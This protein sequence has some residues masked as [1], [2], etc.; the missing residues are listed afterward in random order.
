[1]AQVTS[2]IPSLDHFDC[3]GDPVSV[4]VRWEKWKRALEIYFLAANIVDGVVK[5]ATLLHLGGLSLQDVYYNLPGA[6]AEEAEDVDVYNVA[7]EKLDAYFSPKQSRYY[8]R[9]IFRLMKQDEGERFEAFLVRLRQQADKCKF[10]AKDEHLIDQI[11]EKGNSSELRKKILSAGD[12]VTLHQVITIATTL[13]TVNRQLDTFGKAGSFKAGD[14]DK[15]DIN[16]IDT[17][18]V[19]ARGTA[20][21]CYRCGN[22]KHLSF[23]PEC[24]ARDKKCLKCGIVGHF[25]DYCKTRK[26]KFEHKKDGK[27]DKTKRQ[28]FDNPQKDTEEVDYVFHLDDDEVINCQVGG[29]TIEMLID[30]G[31][32]CNIITDETWEY[33]KSHN[34]KTSNQIAN[35]DKTLV[36]YGS[37]TPLEVTGRFEAQIYIRDALETTAT[38]Y[39]IRNGSRNLMGRI[40]AKQLGVLQT[41][42]PVNNISTFPKFKGVK[43]QI[44]ID[45]KVKPV[46]Q[47]Y[48][49]IPIPLEEKVNSKLI[50]LQEADIIEEVN[51]PSQWVSAM[52]PVLK[53]NGDLRICI[54]MRR[55]NEAIIRE[56]H[57]LPTM[58]ELLPHFRQAK[59]FSRLDIKNAFH[60]LE[61]DED[62]RHITTFS[63]S[64]GLF[65]YKRLMFGVSCAPEMFQKVLEKMLLGCEGTANFIDDIIIYGSDEKEH[66]TRLKKVLQV[67]KDNDVLLNESKCIYKTDKI[68]FLGHELTAKGVKP[69]DKYIQAIQSAKRPTN[70]EEIQSLGALLIQIGQNGPRVIAFGNKSL[71]DCEKRYCQTEKEALALVWAVEH[72]KTYL[73]GKEFEIISDHKPL[74][75]IFGP[76]SKPCARIERWVLRLQAY[77][78]KVIYRPGKDNIADPISRLCQSISPKPFDNENYINAIVQYSRPTA[79]PLKEIEAVCATDEEIMALKSGMYE[80]K[81]HESV[82]AYKAFQT[83]ICFQGNIPL[84]GNKLI[85]PKELRDRVLEAAHRGH[86]GIVAMKTRLRTK[87]WWP[88][89]D[90]DA[91]NRV[92]ACKG[93]TLVSAPNAPH[94]IKRRE[95]PVEP[96]ID[97]AVDFLGPLPSNDY[98]LVLID[99]Y[100]RYKEIKIM[101]SITAVDTVRVLKEI[102][103]R[104]GY[105]ATLTCDNGNQFTSQTFKT[106][107]K[108]CN[109]VIYNTIPYWPQMNGEVERQNRDVLKRLKISQVEKK[110]W[111]D[112][113]LE[114]LI[115]YNST[116][117]ST[118]GKTP[119]E[120]FFRRQ[121][122]DKIPTAADMECKIFDSDVRDRDKEKKEKGREY[123]DRKRKAADSNLEIGEKVYVKNLIKDNKLTPNFNPD[124]RTVTDVSGGDVRVR[125]DATGKEYRRN[126]VHLKKA[127]TGEWSV[128]NKNSES[129]PLPDQD[130]N[131]D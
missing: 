64:K 44:P 41:G 59:F 7:M 62:S 105:P 10:T 19:P 11:I 5:R 16:K 50:E 15:S 34:V 18:K 131:E 96:W 48:R 75:T 91:E 17:K 58:D 27:F 97:V 43:I 63:T 23:A 33:L 122:R 52:V 71:T 113:L 119:S 100:S 98:I 3:G 95:L 88:K 93:C 115:M 4:G 94:P 84:R 111:K 65:R 25:K 68:E 31:C 73:F 8:E 127:E 121:F 118:T 69:L 66:D 110:N 83:E 56:N 1:M 21:T 54:D 130:Q 72:F 26:R 60:Q 109:I 87:V 114:Y 108:E 12:S 49:R 76:R 74:E 129:A 79:V 124:S 123:T 107:C 103:S 38:L 14:I 57:P 32:R 67:L 81:W 55:A 6:H 106:F 112:D 13:E 99:Y 39:V 102:F 37:Q 117:H 45:D 77:K 28:K 24:P 80:N 29:V 120:L 101:R 89:I 22:N 2:T 85:I 128:V 61:I 116:P 36:A 126:V 70:V 30:S 40:T 51:G 104:L 53:E 92:K 42:I 20:K 90:R 125:N 9:Y 35:P 47:P 78:Y 82:S 46:S 86:P